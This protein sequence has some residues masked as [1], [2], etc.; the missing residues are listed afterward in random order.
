MLLRRK[1]VVP[2]M[3]MLKRVEYLVLTLKTQLHRVFVL[4]SCLEIHCGTTFAPSTLFL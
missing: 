3:K 1:K 2:V 4:R